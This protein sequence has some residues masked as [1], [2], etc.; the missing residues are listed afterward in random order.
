MYYWKSP[1]AQERKSETLKVLPRV[2]NCGKAFPLASGHRFEGDFE[3]ELGPRLKPTERNDP[4]V[5]VRERD[6]VFVGG[7][8]QKR[9]GSR[10]CDCGKVF[11]RQTVARL[12][13]LCRNICVPIKNKK[14]KFHL[15]SFSIKFAIFLNSLFD[16][17]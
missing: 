6:S 9:K 17:L 2:F 1:D 11:L 14:K 4:T 3:Y 15:L 10:V 8:K 7:S 12:E 5:L 13:G 16:S